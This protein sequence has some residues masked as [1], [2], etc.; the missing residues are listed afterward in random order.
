MHRVVQFD[1]PESRFIW[2][3]ASSFLT[4]DES[5]PAQPGAALLGLTILNLNDAEI[6]AEFIE[7]D[8]LMVSRIEDYNG[9]I[10]R[11]PPEDA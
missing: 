6:T 8:G 7:I 11:S 1:L 3:A 9:T 5:M 10:Y 2:C 4:Y